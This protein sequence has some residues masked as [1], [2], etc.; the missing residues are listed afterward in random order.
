[1]KRIIS[2]FLATSSI[3]FATTVKNIDSGEIKINIADNQANILNFP[4]LISKAKLVTEDSDK[5][6]VKVERTSVVVVAANGKH[7]EADLLVWSNDH[8]PYLIKMKPKGKEQF[9]NFTSNRVQPLKKENYKFEVGSIDS[10]IK[11]LIKTAMNKDN[12]PGYSRVKVKR[13]FNTR[14]IL[15]QKDTMYNGSKY[16]VEKWYLK[17]KK[18]YPIKLDEADFYTKGILAI[19]FS[20]RTLLPHATGLMYLVINKASLI[21]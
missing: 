15:M 13:I 18:G 1:M 20:E 11:K 7:S 19:A 9:W 17:N 4:F 16:R 2:M 5:F 12:I 21:K 8:Y 3:I 6:N 14:D 10:S